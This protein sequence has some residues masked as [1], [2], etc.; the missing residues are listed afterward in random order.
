MKL[1]ESQ[2]EALEE[3]QRRATSSLVTPSRRP[4]CASKRAE[5]RE[6]VGLEHGALA[7]GE[8]DRAELGNLRLE[9][10]DAAI[11]GVR[12]AGRWSPIGLREV[13]DASDEVP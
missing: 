6:D 3:V 12:H 2:L 13:A 7:T 5:A 1:V 8:D 9:L 10:G 11:L 4:F